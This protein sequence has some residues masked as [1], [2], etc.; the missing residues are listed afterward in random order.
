MLLTS[1]PSS[2]PKTPKP[3][4]HLPFLAMKDR[5]SLS[6][7][8]SIYVP[9]HNRLRSV[10]TSVNSP[11]L[12]A[13]KLRGNLPP[14]PASEQVPKKGNLR[15]VSA[16][17]DGVSEE[18]SDR[19]FD[20]PSLS[21]SLV[22]F[23]SLMSMSMFSFVIQIISVDICKVL[24]YMKL[25][26]YFCLVWNSLGTWQSG[27]TNENL[28]EWKRKLMMLLNDKS[29]QEL[30]SREKKDR[31]DFDQIAVL[32]SRM[33][34]YRCIFCSFFLSFM[35][36]LLMLLNYKFWTWISIQIILVYCSHM[37]AKVVVFSKMPL[38]NYRYDLDDRRP[39]R[40]VCILLL[41]LLSTF[42]FALV[43]YIKQN[44]FTHFLFCFSHLTVCES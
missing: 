27:Y 30:I 15:Y 18:G 11:A 12:V 22:V 37:Y 14:A 1:Q 41:D 6:S 36:W 23:F 38:P 33:G 44:L 16:Y 7:N 17:D 25:D 5:P 43:L 9:P 3:S 32:A 8:G 20:V 40:E 29:K 2:I 4:F 34:L 26:V 21:V 24:C 10:I 31:R 13:A 42:P 35:I 28:I 39:Q 19:E